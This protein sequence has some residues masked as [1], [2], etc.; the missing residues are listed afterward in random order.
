MDLTTRLTHSRMETYC[1]CPKRFFFEYILKLPAEPQY[2]AY[3]E[4]GSRAHKVLEDFYNHVTIPCEPKS[5]FD[6]LIGRLYHH[7]FSNIVDYKKNMMAGLLNFLKMEILRYDDLE[8]K[9]LFIPKHN[10]LYI[11]SNIA[12]IP[13]SGRI[14]AI[15][16]NPDGKLIAVDYKFTSS[17]SIGNTQKQ[18][19][20]IYSILLQKELGI[21]FNEFEFW[22]L[23]HKNRTIKEVKITDKLIENLNKKVNKV[24]NSI[25]NLEF[26][27]KPSWLCRYCGYE[28]LCLTEE[29]DNK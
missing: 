12:G 21:E 22:F 7:E 2:P 18:Q 24:V 13:F 29:M 23:R 1:N 14:D 25:N 5:H 10:E 17:N 3:G 16:E 28:S 8:N 11:K 9:E 20:T 15:Y 26:D 27:R 4:L 6:D 19:A